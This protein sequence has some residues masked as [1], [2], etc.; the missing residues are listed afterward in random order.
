MT[1]QKLGKGQYGDVY[2]MR[3][4][5]RLYAGKVMSKCSIPSV[6]QLHQ[7]V[8]ILQKMAKLGNYNVIGLHDMFETDKNIYMILEY[9]NGG[10]LGR[11]L[12]TRGRFTEDEARYIMRSISKG[13]Q[14]LNKLNVVHRDLKLDNIFIHFMN[15][16]IKDVLRQP[17]EFEMFKLWADIT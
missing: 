17:K 9:C 10:D 15:Y 12:T 5:D 6:S 14:G 16:K 11:M 4:D 1:N 8:S 2:L 7:E 3:K 13:Y